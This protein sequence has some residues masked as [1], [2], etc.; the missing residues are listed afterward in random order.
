MQ[1]FE[2][3][4]NFKYGIIKFQTLNVLERMFPKLLPNLEVRK[5]YG[6]SANGANQNKTQ[7]QIQTK[8]T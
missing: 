2:A 7:T 4:Q 5:Q 1:R 8:S 6:D 3:V